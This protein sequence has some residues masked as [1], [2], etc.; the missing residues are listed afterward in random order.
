MVKA[1]S[2][3]DG[4]EIRKVP[5]TQGI[6]GKTWQEKRT[7][8]VDDIW[9]NREAKPA[10]EDYRSAISAPLGDM[11][12][13]QAISTEVQAFD[14]E[15]VELTETLLS[16]AA[17]ALKRIR[18]EDR[19]RYMSFHDSLTSLYNRAFFDEELARLD[20][21]RQLP[22]SIIM[23]DVNGLKLVNDV[24]GHRKGDGLLRELAD[25]IKGTCRMEDIV[26]RWGGDEFAI[27]LPQT[28]EKRANAICQTIRS[29]CQKSEFDPVQPSLALGMATKKEP[30]MDIQKVL[31]EAED[32]MYRNKLM[33]SRSARSSIITSLEKTLWEKSYETEEHAR[34]M[35]DMAKAIGK[36]L[37]L[38][39]SQMDNL[40]LLAT[41]HDIGK[42][43]IP[44]EI[45]KKPG[46]L[47]PKEW[48][49]VKRH[50]EV[51][52]RIAESSPEL[53]PIAD[54]I[55]A[56]H[57]WYDGTGYPRGLRGEAIPLIA[58][59]IALI[60]AYDVM[61]HGRP[62]KEPMTVKEALKEVQDCAGSQFDPYLVTLFVNLMK[63]GNSNE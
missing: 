25:I 44:E 30:G 15:D 28:D 14:A 3:V 49:V 2:G 27:L 24:F 10:K 62:Y 51:G 17:E 41:L 43:A 31:K 20:T 22:I 19:I 61:L 8:V 48:E 42:I 32:R 58:R 21:H 53:G 55:L 33:E 45:I 50:P 11:G 12:I 63:G 37:K 47:T 1:T 9:E 26:A 56:H 16:H 36:S 46:P 5:V 23:G 59:I 54:A 13:F 4:Q 60:D 39:A 18:Y 35:Q 57:E 38:S 6:G 40:V 29:R 7:I 34:R 52:F